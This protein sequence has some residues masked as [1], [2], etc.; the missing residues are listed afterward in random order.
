MTHRNQSIP[1]PQAFLNNFISPVNVISPRLLIRP[2]LRLPNI[3]KK[4]TSPKNLKLIPG[5]HLRQNTY[6]RSKFIKLG[7]IAALNGLI[8][9]RKW[10]SIRGHENLDNVEISYDAEKTFFPF[11]LVLLKLHSLLNAFTKAKNMHKPS[12]SRCLSLV[13]TRG[14]SIDPKDSIFR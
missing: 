6:Q 5:Q 11:N 13:K 12:E 9:K 2:T 1:F 14:S 10:I 7:F 8:H 4:S 3:V